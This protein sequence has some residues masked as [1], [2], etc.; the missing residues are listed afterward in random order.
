MRVSSLIH[1]TPLAIPH[2]TG[3]MSFDIRAQVELADK[4]EVRGRHKSEYDFVEMPRDWPKANQ[5]I[6]FCIDEAGK[7]NYG[8]S[9]GECGDKPLYTMTAAFPNLIKG[10]NYLDISGPGYIL[11]VSGDLKSIVR[12]D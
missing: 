6:E 2:V 7:Y 12:S 1:F 4:L 5:Y 8:V 9:N 11:S 10:K 3:R